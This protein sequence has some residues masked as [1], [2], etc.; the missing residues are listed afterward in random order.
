MIIP[1][2]NFRFTP[3]AP[4]RIKKLKQI[5]KYKGSR[6]AKYTSLI[7][8]N[9]QTHRLKKKPVMRAKYFQPSKTEVQKKKH[10]HNHI[11]IT[12]CETSQ[13]Q[14]RQGKI[15][16]QR[17]VSCTRCLANSLN[18]FCD[19]VCVMGDHKQC[20]FI[21]LRCALTCCVWHLVLLGSRGATKT[22]CM[23]E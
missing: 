12:A 2:D 18:D 15:C 4:K 22:M 17:K 23:C 6:F 9:I 5:C 16:V 10:T 21:R 1:I 11:L 7:P 19:C 3:R 8:H 20:L 13:K 14:H